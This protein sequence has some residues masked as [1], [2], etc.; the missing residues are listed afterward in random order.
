MLNILLEVNPRLLEG[1]K[2]PT[3]TCRVVYRRY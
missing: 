2:L 1:N 3:D